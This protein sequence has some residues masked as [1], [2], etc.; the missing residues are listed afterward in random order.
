M[1][2]APPA[3]DQ[4]EDFAHGDVPEDDDWIESAL[5]QATDLFWLATGLMVYPSDE[6]ETRVVTYAI[7]EMA[8]YLLTQ[9]DNKTQIFGPYSSE[10]IGSYSYS[11]MPS[12]KSSIQSGTPMGL[13]W[14]DRA[15][16]LFS[17]IHTSLIWSTSEKVMPRS[18]GEYLDSC[19]P[20]RNWDTW[21]HDWFGR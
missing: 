4:Y 15:I 5:Q 20:Q 17:T 18:Y 19:D 8:Q 1:S 7:L 2:L 11:K 13:L 10:R 16:S 14:W 21:R 12:V 6:L 3:I 9:D